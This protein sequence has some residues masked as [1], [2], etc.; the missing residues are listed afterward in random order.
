MVVEDNAVN[1]DVAEKFLTRLGQDVTMARDGAEGVRLAGELPFDLIFMDMQMPVMD[2]IGA[3]RAI[4]A[5]G[6]MVPIIA[7]TANASDDDLARCLE[8]GMNG[9]EAKPVSMARMAEL[10]V[11]QVGQSRGNVAIEPASL[12]AV[13]DLS[14]A[15]TGGEEGSAPATAPAGLTA[16][17]MSNTRMRELIDVVGQEGFDELFAAFTMDAAL[18]LSDLREAMAMTDPKL[19][20]RALHS[21]KGSAANLGFTGLADIAEGGRHGKID[22]D[23]VERIGGEIERMNARPTALGAVRQWTQN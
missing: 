16:E 7:L 14:T 2:G 15:E 20:D 21:L 12:P 4:R 22:Q 17:E 10:I 13:A 23:L 1:R 18:L 6:N 9:F 5:T 8:A 19:A 3:T 11:E